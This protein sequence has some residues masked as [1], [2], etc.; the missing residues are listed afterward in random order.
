MVAR[1]LVGVAPMRACKPSPGT[2]CALRISPGADIAASNPLGHGLNEVVAAR[3]SPCRLLALCEVAHSMISVDTGPAHVAA[4]LGS[5]LVVMFGNTSPRHW[6]PRS[7]LGGRIIALGGPPGVCHVDQISVPEV[8]EAWRSLPV[9]QNSLSG[10]PIG[11][12]R[13]SVSV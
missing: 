2:N 8:F 12:D 13:G 3:L 4:A 5:P 1:E 6:L 10:G 9:R 11:P 7:V